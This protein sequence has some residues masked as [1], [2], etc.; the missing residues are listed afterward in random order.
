MN[1]FKILLILV[2]GTFS[3]SLCDVRPAHSNKGRVMS[4]E[5]PEE[6]VRQRRLEELLKDKGK[7]AV[8][9]QP[10]IATQILP[11]LDDPL[12]GLRVRAVKAL[13]ELE[14]PIAKEPL[15]KKLA[16]MEA[17]PQEFQ[18]RIPTFALKWALGRIASRGLHGQAKIDA[19]LSRL[20][21]KWMDVVALSKSTSAI[22]DDV[23]HSSVDGEDVVTAVVALLYDMGK[24][25]E[26][27]GPLSEQLT[28]LP[29]QK[30]Y[31][32]AASLNNQ[33]AV[34]LLLRVLVDQNAHGRGSRE[35]I[36]LF[37]TLQP[38][39]SR[40]V[41]L[42]LQDM[43]AHPELYYGTEPYPGDP[44]AFRKRMAHLPLLRAASWTRDPAMIPLL[45][46]FEQCDEPEVRQSATQMRKSIERSNS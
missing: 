13:G 8:E 40:A 28:L 33:E 7:P 21:G 4:A 37:M 42:R 19:A 23:W 32:Q 24:A 41:L 11:F 5:T 38:E 18:V 46:E 17:P 27:I 35:L 39:A 12:S 9:G 29:T 20:G 26:D 16:E 15:E 34:E 10:S 1:H 31:I 22:P 2:L 6:K 14:D 43:K 30:T 36:W 45:R 3:F 44:N 25:G